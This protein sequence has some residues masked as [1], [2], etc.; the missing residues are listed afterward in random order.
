MLNSRNKNKNMLKLVDENTTRHTLQQ[1]IIW[2]ALLLD[3]DWSTIVQLIY[4]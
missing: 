1:I 2:S 3:S 4:L